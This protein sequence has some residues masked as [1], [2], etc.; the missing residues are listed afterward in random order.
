ME[1]TFNALENP[2]GI[3]CF[4]GFPNIIKVSDPNTGTKASAE[5]RFIPSFMRQEGLSLTINGVT[6]MS[7][8]DPSLAVGNKF[9]LPT[10]PATDTALGATYMLAETLRNLPTISVNYTI[11]VDIQ[12]ALETSSLAV[13]KITARQP[14]PQY[15]LTIEGTALSRLT[16]A[17][18]EGTNTSQLLSGKSNRIILDVYCEK[19]TKR[20][21]NSTEDHYKGE[22]VTSL[23]KLHHGEET[24]FDITPLMTSLADYGKL[25]RMDIHVL[26]L[27]DGAV[28]LM[29]VFEDIYFTTG[30]SVNQQLP[31]IPQF[32]STVLAQN[33]TRGTEWQY[34][35][36]TRLQIAIPSLPV[37]LYTAEGYNMRQTRIRYYNSADV[38]LHEQTTFLNTLNPFSEHDITL[39]E[40]WFN[41][42]AYITMNVAG[43]GTV[44]YDVI[45]P[46]K[47]SEQTQ[48]IWWTNSMG[49][50]SFADFTGQRTEQRKTKV[51]YYQQQDFGFYEHDKAELNKVYDKQIDIT[52]SL[53]S[54]YIVKDATWLYFDLQNSLNAWTLVNGKRYAITVTDIKITETSAKGTYMVN[55]DYEYSMADTY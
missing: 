27:K 9:Y 30:Y 37:S 31:Y 39:D 29:Q 3:T 23:E 25:S 28:S 7:T 45:K 21:Y 2:R 6:I 8:T 51:E 38:L 16:V 11:T 10:T 1:I 15:N 17:T 33:V 34:T 12:Q 24:Y 44:R 19:D 55:L 35:N 43:T 47:A 48:R 49:G 4:T 5:I 54:S 40:E 18:T 53:T 41:K 26:Y 36:N 14:G 22:Y 20:K 32:N 50:T 42:S 13:L 46:L 52:V